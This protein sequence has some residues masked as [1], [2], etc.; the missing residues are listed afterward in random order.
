MYIYM[1]I[2]KYTKCTY[3]LYVWLP[4]ELSMHSVDSIY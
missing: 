2:Y 3:K 1:C 4:E